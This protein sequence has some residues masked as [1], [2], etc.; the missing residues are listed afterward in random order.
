MTFHDIFSSKKE[1]PSPKAHKIIID[2]HEKNSLVPAELA[3][4]K[5]PFRFEH[6]EVGDYLI[7]SFVIERKTINDLKSSIISKRVFSQLQN[8]KQHPSPLLLI[9]G[10]QESLVNNEILHENAMRGFLLSLAQEKFPCIVTRDSKDTALC[11]ALLARK[12]PSQEISLRPSRIFASKEEQLQFILEGFPHIGPIKAKALL[13][14]CGSLKNIFN[15]KEKELREIL[16]AYTEE[17]I[18]LLTLE[19]TKYKNQQK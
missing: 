8:L 5:I 18:Q 13:K 14:Q 16:G 11:L 3:T 19:K 6:L 2:L 12:K 17:F 1:P 7:N 15:A 4:L 10:L 9:E